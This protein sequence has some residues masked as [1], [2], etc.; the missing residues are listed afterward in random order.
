MCYHSAARCA[1]RT[2]LG[3]DQMVAR[4]ISPKNR[5]LRTSIA[6]VNLV[7]GFARQTSQRRTFEP[8]CPHRSSTSMTQPTLRSGRP[9]ARSGRAL[10]GFL[11]GV[12][13]T[14]ILVVVV[15]MPL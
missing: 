13:L 8:Y 3:A 1:R 5:P 9:P 14:L 15:G 10:L 4:A 7:A 12:I 11:I 6:V 2:L